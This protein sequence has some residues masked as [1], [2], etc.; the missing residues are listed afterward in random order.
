MEQPTWL[1]QFNAIHAHARH[2]NSRV[3]S[4][5]ETHT[6]GVH[7]VY[8]PCPCVQWRDAMLSAGMDLAPLDV[9]KLK[10]MAAVPSGH[11]QLDPPITVYYDGSPMPHAV[12]FPNGRVEVFNEG[13]TGFM[14]HVALS[15]A[16]LSTAPHV[17]PRLAS[18]VVAI[19]TNGAAF[20]ALR[21]DK[22]VVCWG[23]NREG[24][25]VPPD[26]AP[27]LH[28]GVVEVVASRAAF[29]ARMSDGTV[30]AWG[31]GSGGA[32]VDIRERLK[33]VTSLVACKEAFAARMG[34]GTL[35]AWGWRPD[36]ER[37]AVV[38][39]SGVLSVRPIPNEPASFE[40]LL[41]DMTVDILTEDYFQLHM[42]S[43]PTCTTFGSPT[44]PA[45]AG[46]G[47]ALRL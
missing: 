10:A 13:G 22:D 46:L 29:A 19:Y 17:E 35:V 15:T 25:T 41:L 1:D 6:G 27:H 36:D 31:C 44:A 43:S 39:V 32:I 21:N 45:P 24:G 38:E 26:V 9:S 23:Y 30:V 14:T 11:V 7:V 20:V 34:D 5:V 8:Q 28:G 4:Y 12:L 3:V 42:D 18:G 2:S 16:T 37:P 40:I 47:L 33:D